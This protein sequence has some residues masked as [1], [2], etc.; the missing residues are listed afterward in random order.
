M[1]KLEEFP[2]EVRLEMQMN[3]LKWKQF[4]DILAE[5]KLWDVLRL[6]REAVEERLAKERG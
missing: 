2:E 5:E 6:Y 4:L 3:L 1:T